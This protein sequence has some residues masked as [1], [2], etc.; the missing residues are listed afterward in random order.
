M[1]LGVS[2]LN[3]TLVI[4]RIPWKYSAMQRVFLLTN[5]LKCFHDL[6]NLIKPYTCSHGNQKHR[7][8]VNEDFTQKYRINSLLEFQKCVYLVSYKMNVFNTYIVQ[9]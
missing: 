8:I 3:S 6:I 9:T 5:V 4:I 7:K 1:V 2:D